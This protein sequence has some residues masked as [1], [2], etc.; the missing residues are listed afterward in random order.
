ME[1]PVF[2]KS[3][4]KRYREIAGLSDPRYYKIFYSRIDPADILVV[5]INPA[6]D[7]QT[8]PEDVRRSYPRDWAEG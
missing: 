2:M 7:P 3:L 1:T 6:G 4:D 5:G 8:W